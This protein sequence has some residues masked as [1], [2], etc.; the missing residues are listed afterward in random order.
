MSRLRAFK[1]NG[2]N[3]YTLFIQRRKQELKEERILKLEKRSIKKKI[4][5]TSANEVMGNIPL[6]QDGRNSGMRT[7]LKSIRGA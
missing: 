1:A 3:V 5:S 7:I 2:G 4:I 6:L